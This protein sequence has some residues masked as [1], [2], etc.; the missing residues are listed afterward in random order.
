MGGTEGLIIVRRIRRLLLHQFHPAI[1]SPSVFRFVRRH[2]RVGA[3]AVSLESGRRYT[4][5]LRQYLDHSCS[6][7]TGFIELANHPAI[8]LMARYRGPYRILQASLRLKL[9]ILHR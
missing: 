4:V 1:Q 2:R 5:L 7:L 9:M 8:E 3:G 6:P